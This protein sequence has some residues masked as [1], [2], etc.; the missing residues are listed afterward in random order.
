MNRFSLLSQTVVF[1]FTG[2]LLGKGHRLDHRFRTGD[3]VARGKNAR[4][5]S[6]SVIIGLK[7]RKDI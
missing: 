5:G 7:Q 1:D 6:M 4:R 2:D 3:D